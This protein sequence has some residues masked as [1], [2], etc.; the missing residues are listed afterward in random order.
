M[1]MEFSVVAAAQWY[2]ELVAYLASHR[3]HL[4]ETNVMWIRWR[5]AA[6]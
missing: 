5:T 1:P 3:A 6:H 2:A 4:G